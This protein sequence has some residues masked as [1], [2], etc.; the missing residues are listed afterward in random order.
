VGGENETTG[1][2]TEFAV[3]PREEGGT[4]VVVAVAMPWCGIK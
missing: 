2:L 3:Y 4:M 1:A